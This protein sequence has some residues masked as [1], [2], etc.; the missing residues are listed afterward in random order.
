MTRADV[1]GILTRMGVPYYC[2]VSRLPDLT[3]VSMWRLRAAI[4]SRSLPRSGRGTVARADLVRWISGQ[5]AIIAH[6]LEAQREMDGQTA[7][8]GGLA[9]SAAAMTAEVTLTVW[10]NYP[11]MKTD[12]N[13]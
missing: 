13:G 3:G 11:R 1:E 10:G 9:W 8:E 6:L 2:K 12:E 5:P 4:D 7:G